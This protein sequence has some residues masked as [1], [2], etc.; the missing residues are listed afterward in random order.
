MEWLNGPLFH[1]KP[2]LAFSGKLVDIN[3][4]DQ[5]KFA[6]RYSCVKAKV[7][8]AQPMSGFAPSLVLKVLIIIGYPELCN[9]L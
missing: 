3:L 1:V 7:E 6:W 9:V 5:A 8:S 4:T 2:F